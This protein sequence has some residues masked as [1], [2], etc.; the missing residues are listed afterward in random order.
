M[1]RDI[2]TALAFVAALISAP[3][4][5]LVFALVN[6]GS[7]PFGGDLYNN[8]PGFVMIVGYGVIIGF[9]PSILTLAGYCMLRDRH[10]LRWWLA[11]LAGACTAGI[12]LFF[13]A[14]LTLPTVI[15]CCIGALSGLTFWALLGREF[16]QPEY[17][18]EFEGG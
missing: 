3:V 6:T 5:F 7:P 17:V 13:A 8:I 9:I 2:R 12:P 4:F 15:F 1:T 10:P 16:R 18:S 11:T 14:G